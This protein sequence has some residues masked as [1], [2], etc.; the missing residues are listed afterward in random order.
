[1]AGPRA[2]LA[3]SIVNELLFELAVRCMKNGECRRRADVALIGYGRSYPSGRPATGLF[4][5]V[6]ADWSARPIPIPD[7]VDNP[8]RIVQDSEGETYVWLEPHAHGEPTM[9][10]GLRLAKT[11]IEEWIAQENHRESFPPV[12]FHFSAG[13]STDISSA[14]AAAQ[15]IKEVT[16]SDGNALLISVYLDENSEPGNLPASKPPTQLK[17]ECQMLFEMASLFPF[18]EAWDRDRGSLVPTPE[19]SRMFV[20]NAMPFLDCFWC[21]FAKRAIVDPPS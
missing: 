15:E 20:V 8:F 5:G 21:A 7:L 14:I 18:P 1:M 3:A 6:S 11:V 10:E 2:E 13:A 19:G 12:V 17:T 4:G 16:T 9:A